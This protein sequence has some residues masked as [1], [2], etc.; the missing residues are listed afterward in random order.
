MEVIRKANIIVQA[1]KQKKEKKKNQAIKDHT[2]DWLTDATRLKLVM[3]NKR[4]RS[5]FLQCREIQLIQ[6]NS[7]CLGLLGLLWENLERNFKDS[8]CWGKDLRKYDRDRD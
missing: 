5:S 4:T 8:F 7:Q 1:E 3:K 2:I 6:P